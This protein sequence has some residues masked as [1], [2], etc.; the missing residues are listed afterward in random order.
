MLV[1]FEKLARRLA[2]RKT[3]ILVVLIVVSGAVAWVFLG[4]SPEDQD[5]W[6][7]PAILA[8]VWVLLLYSGLLLFEQVPGAA[9]DTGGWFNRAM[10]KLKRGCYHLF[11]WFMLL[12]SA[13]VIIV[14]FQLGMAWIRML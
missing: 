7:I 10:A 13:A 2:P 14:T 5:R 3:L 6:L 1:L 8:Q 9:G 12:V 4:M 11:A